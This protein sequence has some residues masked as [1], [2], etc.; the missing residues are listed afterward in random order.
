MLEAARRV[1]D[2]RIHSGCAPAQAAFETGAIWLST[3]TIVLSTLLA[4]RDDCSTVGAITDT[5]FFD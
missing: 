1:Q 3:T 4:S 5:V 2:R